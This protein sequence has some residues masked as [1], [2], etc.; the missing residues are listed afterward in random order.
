MTDLHPL[1]VPQTLY[2]D[3]AASVVH[4]RLVG[5]DRKVDI[6]FPFGDLYVYNNDGTLLPGFPFAA[7][8]DITSSPA[9]G[10]INGVGCDH[11]VLANPQILPEVPVEPAA[12]LT[13]TATDTLLGVVFG[14]AVLP[15]GDTV[16]NP[17]YTVPADAPNPLTNTVTLS[18]SLPEG[19]TNEIGRASG[20][21]RV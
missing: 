8:G 4:D 16:L 2:A 13:C 11:G 7:G 21:E 9:V 12:D 10:D 17:T 15:A 1:L 20:R 18:C 14:P 3:I 5:I 19:Y 6:T